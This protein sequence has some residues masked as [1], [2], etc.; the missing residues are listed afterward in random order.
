[1]KQ[2]C[3]YFAIVMMSQLLCSCEH[4]ELDFEGV[5]GLTVKFDWTSVNHA[6]PSYMMLAAFTNT[7]QPIQKHIEGNNSGFMRLPVGIYNFISYNGD[8][9]DLST[10]GYTW[11]D[12]EIYSLPVNLV[13]VSR[14]F[15]NTRGIPKG[16]GTENQN[17]VN[18]PNGLWTAANS[19]VEVTGQVG[20]TIKMN[21]ESATYDLHFT[22]KNVQNMEFINEVLATISGMSESWYPAQHR[23]SETLCIIPFQLISDGNSFEGVVRTFGYR[24]EDNPQHKLVIYSEMTTGSKLYYTFDVSDAINNAVASGSGDVYIE[25][26]E[27]PLPKPVEGNTGLQP[28]VVDWEEVLIPL[29][30]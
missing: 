12:F 11:E 13:D 10:R 25:L 21:M 24:K 17:F 26:E 3:I 6:N 8:I 18:E 16:A 4:K 22:I 19:N 23:C 2:V 30:M 29:P 1:M 28:D 27:L 14:M 9:E 5:A 15:A 7:S 20:E